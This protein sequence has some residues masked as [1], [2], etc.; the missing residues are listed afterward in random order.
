MGLDQRERLGNGPGFLNPMSILTRPC[1]GLFSIV[2]AASLVG[3]C[4]SSAPP[5]ASQPAVT[6][7]H[8]APSAEKTVAIRAPAATEDEP[9]PSISLGGAPD[10]TSTPRAAV[11]SQG[12]KVTRNDII[13]ALQPVQTLLG[14]WRGI[15]RKEVGDFKAS[16]EPEWVWDL[17]TDREHPA[18]VMTSDQGQYFRSGR[19]TWDAVANQFRLTG[20]S[21]EGRERVFAGTFSEPPEEF[22]E[23]GTIVHTKFKL[24]LDEVG[25]DEKD[26]WQVVIS[27]QNNDRYLMELSKTRAGDFA[28]FDTVGHQR[29][30]TSFAKSDTDY[31]ERK[32]IISGGLGTIQVSYQGKS[33]WVCCTGCQA[34]FN[35]DPEGWLRDAKLKSAAK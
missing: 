30:G 10:A 20:T 34:A 35:E 13:T 24:Q 4:N 14:K 9:L 22:Q 15:T 17:R 1:R 3:G 12:S 5:T 6:P 7:T 8:S 31:G 28:R 11:V 16:D 21:P 29:Q 19:L 27:Q 33:Y 32:C 26:R 23:A 18:L 25:G 2:A